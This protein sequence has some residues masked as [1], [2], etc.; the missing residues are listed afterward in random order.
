MIHCFFLMSRQGRSRLT[1]W[2]SSAMSQKEKQKFL[3]E[4][5]RC[6]TSGQYARPD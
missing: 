4:V 5:H 2:Y 1:K 3:R 6:L